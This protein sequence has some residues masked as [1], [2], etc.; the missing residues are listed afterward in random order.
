M[1][2]AYGCPPVRQSGGSSTNSVPVTDKD[3]QTREIKILTLKNVLFFFFPPWERWMGHELK[4]DNVKAFL[5][6]P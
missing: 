1:T 4:L 5:L 3:T 6:I 2:A